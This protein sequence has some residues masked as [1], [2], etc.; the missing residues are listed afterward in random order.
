MFFCRVFEVRVVSSFVQLDIVDNV[1]LFGLDALQH[2]RSLLL[3][4][5]EADL[6]RPSS[7]DDQLSGLLRLTRLQ[8]D[9][10]ECW[11]DGG[12]L[13]A[14]RSLTSLVSLHMRFTDV[15]AAVL[16]SF[17][18]LNQLM[19]ATLF[20]PENNSVVCVPDLR[21]IHMDM[22]DTVDDAV[23][24]ALSRTFPGLTRLV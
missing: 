22:L 17:P 9:G 7:I 5:T 20:L 1:R 13:L 8:V 3:R 24:K 23:P 19:C 11:I 21:D 15:H 18:F 2:L 14:R 16:S 4:E 12:E 10:D 6:Y